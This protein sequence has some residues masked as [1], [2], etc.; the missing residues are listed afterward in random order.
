MYCVVFLFV[1]TLSVSAVVAAAVAISVADAAVDKTHWQWL[2]LGR[3]L[4][5]YL[6]WKP[7]HRVPE[8]VYFSDV[9]FFFF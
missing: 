5:F 6:G 4:V 2:I 8:G 9:Q 3:R 7:L 1:L